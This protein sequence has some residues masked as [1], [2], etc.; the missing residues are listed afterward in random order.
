MSSAAPYRYVERQPSE[1]AAHWVLAYWSFA[2]DAT[3][4]PEQP[5]TVWPDGCVSLSVPLMG[6]QVGPLLCVGPRVVAL[7]PPVFAGSRLWGIRFWPD[8]A[9]TL[10]GSA[11][12]ALRDITGEA[13]P[14]LQEWAAGLRESVAS[15]GSDDA[16]FA[17][18][19]A[20][21]CARLRAAPIPDAPVRRAVQTLVA[22]RGE[23]PAAEVAAQAGL[24]LRQLQ[25]RFAAR[26][27]LTLREW[28][29]VR[30]LRES[31]AQR[32]QSSTATWSRIAAEVGF[33]DHA[34]LAREFVQLTGFSPSQAAR[35]LREISHENVRP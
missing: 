31:L 14:S 19:D 26:T 3:P 15:A 35:A 25:R 16:R 10:F 23:L 11:A 4:P 7:Q 18:L 9:G 5:Y 33:V 27:G 13:P 6:G 32:L 34:H 20:W 28:A 8:A 1:A 30:R 22:A 21:A 2:A 29:R 24:G 17:V 12:R